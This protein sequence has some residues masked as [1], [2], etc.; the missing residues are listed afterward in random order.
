MAGHDGLYDR[1]PH[2]GAAGIAAG[3]E[4]GIEYLLSVRFGY[5]VTII[6]HGHLDRGNAVESLQ[7]HMLRIVTDRIVGQV[8][9]HDQRLLAGHADRTFEATGHV[10]RAGR[11]SALEA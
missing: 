10:D 5:R 3:G 8:R 4:E 1:E 6:T 7:P 2:P 11:K 9:Q